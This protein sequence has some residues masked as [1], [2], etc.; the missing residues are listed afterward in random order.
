[1]KKYIKNTIITLTWLL[2]IVA[3]AGI[4]KF[5]FTDNDIYVEKNWDIVPISTVQKEKIKVVTSIVPLASIANAVWWE[6]VEVISVIPAWVSPHN[7]DLAPK[8]VIDIDNSDVVIHIWLEHV[9]G[10][11]KKAMWE[12]RNLA[13]SEWFWLI[14]SKPHG[15]EEHDDHEHEKDPHIWVSPSN[16]IFIAEKIK[17]EL[18][19]LNWDFSEEFEENYVKFRRG[20]QKVISEFRNKTYWKTTKHFIVL[21]DAY[22]YLFNELWI[23]NEKKI[24]F[25]KSIMNNPSSKELKEIIDNIKTHEINTI[26]TEPQFNSSRLKALAWEYDM[27]VLPLDPLGMDTSE[28]WYINNLSNNINNIIELYE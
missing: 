26:Y 28:Q 25:Q 1:M 16:A 9:D 27:Q 3:I 17:N 4:Y 7:F 15:H 19:K 11:L 20:I 22:S 14:E 2:S 8:Q 18:T 10:F 12:K 21:H 24:V 13:V 23:D 5:N 6:H